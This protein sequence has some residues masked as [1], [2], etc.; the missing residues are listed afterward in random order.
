VAVNRGGGAKVAADC[1]A[2]LPV[3][4]GLLALGDSKLIR[5]PW[6]ETFTPR[7]FA[8]EPEAKEALDVVVLLVVAT[9]ASF[10]FDPE[11]L[12]LRS[13]PCL[14]EALAERADSARI[15]VIIASATSVP[16]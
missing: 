1:V 15:A 14:P 13:T 2:F 16:K 9:A 6:S 11:T 12:C 7:K 4:R 10:L 3:E 8:P 5:L